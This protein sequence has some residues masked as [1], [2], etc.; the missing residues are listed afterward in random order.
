MIRRETR[1]GPAILTL[2]RPAPPNSLAEAMLR[3]L[4]A[5]LDN[6]AASDC[7]AP[8]GAATALAADGP[9]ASAAHAAAIRRM[10]SVQA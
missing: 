2:D 1:D 10:A 3:D 7:R 6:L 9:A 4:T 8:V 5:R